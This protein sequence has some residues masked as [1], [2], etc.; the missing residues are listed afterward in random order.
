[1]FFNFFSIIDSFIF[2]RKQFLLLLCTSLLLKQLLENFLLVIRIH[3]Y[4][5]ELITN[6]ENCFFLILFLKKTIFFQLHYLLDIIVCD[7]LQKNLK[8]RFSVT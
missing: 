3:F 5:F 7:Y 1:V 4:A 8:F 6:L 2:F